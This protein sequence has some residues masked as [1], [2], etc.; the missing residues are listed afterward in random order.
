MKTNKLHINSIKQKLI[1]FFKNQSGI[2]LAFLFGSVAERK[3]HALSDIDM[4][5]YYGKKPTFDRHLRLIN[6]VSSLL[7]TDNIDVVNMNTASPLI[8]Q[9]I[10]SFGELLLCNDDALYTHLRL[11][12]LRDYDDVI[13]IIKIQGQYIFGEALHG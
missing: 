3:T 12:T 7:G 8:L 5:V 2:R 6:E 1:P 13:H 4:A 9:D 11:K 10:F